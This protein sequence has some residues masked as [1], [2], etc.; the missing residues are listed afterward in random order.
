[1][2]IKRKQKTLAGLFL[3]FA[4]LFSVNTVLIFAGCMLLLIG[5]SFLGVT[6]QA[7]YAEI[8]LT[9]HTAEIRAA[10]ES[11]EEWIPKGCTYGIYDAEGK[12][13]SGT[14]PVEEREEAWRHYK[15]ENIYAQKSS[16]YRFII[17]DSGDVCIVKY[18]LYMKYA[19]DELNDKLPTPEV[20][21]FIIDGVLFVLNAVFLSGHFAKRLNRE[22]GKLREITDRIAENNLEFAAK[23]SDVREIGEVMSSLSQMKDALKGSLTVQWEMEQQKQEQ[24]AALAHDI[25]TPLTIIRGNAELLEENELSAESKECT[26]YI[27]SNV[28]D[29]EQYLEH[30]KQVLHG[31]S[32]ADTAEVIPC[33]RLGELLQRAAVQIAAAEKLPVSF[34]IEADEGE[35]CCSPERICRAWKNVLSNAA[36]RTDKERGIE[37][38]LKRCRRE[39]QEY[40]AASVRDY[41][42]GFSARDL[43]YADQEFYSG[44]ASRHDRKHQGLGLSIAKKFLEEQGGFL[45]FCNRTDQEGAEVSC[46]LRLRG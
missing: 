39:N 44:D 26:D 17:Q 13:K 28:S 16:Y 11:P 30:I 38:H 21:S 1:M 2:E 34:D 7:N 12:W 32:P 10:G 8:H 27:L 45:Q 15:E 29:I 6:L 5:C 42:A 14:F 18:D 33:S 20:M 19:R 36:E 3:K 23:P 24:L 40:M 46:W 4:V 37:I 35:V 22:L 25:K 43:E 41:G 9:K 31:S